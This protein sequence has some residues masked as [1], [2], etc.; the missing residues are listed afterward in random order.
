MCV[1]NLTEALFSIICVM[2]NP[3]SEQIYTSEI[4]LFFF[5]YVWIPFELPLSIFSGITY[6]L[7]SSLK[8]PWNYCD[9]FYRSFYK[10]LICKLISFSR[11][12]INRHVSLSLQFFTN[13]GSQNFW[14]LNC[15][16]AFCTVLQSIFTLSPCT[17]TGIASELYCNIWFLCRCS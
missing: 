5:I 12:F 16:I 8:F 15:A 10:L 3:L 6:Q 4:A 14:F 9:H 2:V 7:N 17:L 1:S 11:N 13:S